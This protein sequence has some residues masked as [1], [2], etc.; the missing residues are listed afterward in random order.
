[1]QWEGRRR[2]SRLEAGSVWQAAGMCNIM[3]RV[4]SRVGAPGWEEGARQAME[5]MGCA[6][7]TACCG[8]EYF[9]GLLRKLTACISVPQHVV[10][11]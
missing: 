11:S 10:G 6:Y 7:G 8:R 2:A 4:C 3:G 5:G 9:I 1:M